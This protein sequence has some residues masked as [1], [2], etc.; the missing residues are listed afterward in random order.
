MTADCP[1]VDPTQIKKFISLFYKKKLNYLSNCAPYEERTYAVGSDIE[2]FRF[3][4]LKKYLYLKTTTFQKEHISPFFL[5]NFKKT[6]LVKSKENLSK[7]RYTLDYPMDLHVI[8]KIIKKSK[9]PF[10][11]KYKEIINI[12]KKNK[13]ISSKNSRYVSIYYEKKVKKGY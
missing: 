11:L 9:K 12:L 1:L 7:F 4:S 10:N 6:Y 5:K 13:K 3:K 2:I 8:K